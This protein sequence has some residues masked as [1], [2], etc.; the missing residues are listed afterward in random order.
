MFAFE[1][2]GPSRRAML[3]SPKAGQPGVASQY[4]WAAGALENGCLA[5]P[6]FAVALDSDVYA[7]MALSFFSAVYK[8]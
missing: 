5:P 7:E 3:S 2:A 4:K 1:C 8:F 6:K